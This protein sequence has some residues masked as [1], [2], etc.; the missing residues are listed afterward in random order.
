M[1]RFPAPA[2]LLPHAG[3]AVLLDE[4]LSDRDDIIE[5]AVSITAAHPFFIAGHGVPAWVGIELMAQ[6]VAA[7]GGLSGRR[8]G[9]APRRGMLL[10]TRR[11]EAS[12]PWF[13]EGARLIIRAER[14]FGG[15][16]GMAA[17]TCRIDCGGQTLAEARLTI[18][19]E[20]DQ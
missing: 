20:E 18:I 9:R 12:V 11:Y 8:A 4:I 1:T 3:P 13:E 17:C 5:A 2:D 19:E 7:H 6:A 14:E 15:E 10:G 16:G